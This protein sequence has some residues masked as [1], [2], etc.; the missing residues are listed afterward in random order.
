MRTRFYILFITFTAFSAFQILSAQRSPDVLT[1]TISTHLH[2]KPID[3]LLQT[4]KFETYK[5]T[6]LKP[7]G[8]WE[9]AEVIRYRLDSIIRSRPIKYTDSLLFHSNSLL[10]PLVYMGKKLRPIELPDF[11]Q[12]KLYSTPLPVLPVPKTIFTSTE[13]YTRQLRDDL[14]TDITMSRSDL[15]T[16]T[17]DKL[18]PSIY[19]REHYISH[20]PIGKISVTGTLS[21]AERSKIELEEIQKMY[22]RKKANALLQFSQNY[23]SSNWYQ[24]GN[25]N[26]AFLSILN[27]QMLYD[28]FKNVQWENN[29]EWRAGFNSV[30]GSALRKIATNDDLI[31]Y[32]TKFG[33]KAY[34]KW[35]YSISGEAST[36]FFNNYKNI[37]SNEL[38][39]KLL[40]PL[41]LNVSLGMDYKYKKIF[42]LMIAPFSFKYIYAYDT[43]H[44]NPNL[45]GI[46]K[47]ENKLYEMGSSLRAQLS[48]PVMQNWQLE[49]RFTFFSNYKKVEMD[50]EIVNVFN[51]NRFI[52]MRLMLNPR[53]DNTIILK[54]GE[55]SRIQFKQL[56]SIGLSFRFF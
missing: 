54:E 14:R 33:V 8:K 21:A 44:V 25:S 27:G 24:G 26:L 2:L 16:N 5:Y 42:S 11:E 9:S 23:I 41:R 43:V 7:D 48:Y 29:L 36:Q 35:Y 45:F 28:N 17:Y 38:K 18:P 30:E 56:S 13:E 46:Q 20:R 4:P 34:G 31:R 50:W 10:T 22:W 53:Y 1:D 49:S 12:M 3:T 40:T 15:Y 37:N 51:F 52:S 6:V 39:S 19:F 47:G 32:T 55:T